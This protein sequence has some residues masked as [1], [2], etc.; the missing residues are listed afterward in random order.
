[1]NIFIKDFFSKC[2]K[3]CNL[4]RI[5]SHLLNKSLMENFICAVIPNQVSQ[6]S[7]ICYKCWYCYWY[8]FTIRYIIHSFTCF[9]YLASEMCTDFFVSLFI[10]KVLATSCIH[11]IQSRWVFNFLLHRD[12]FSS[13]PNICCILGM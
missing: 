3:I 13:V 9:D 6:L 11:F 4:L 8:Y 5:W 12:I 7:F 10:S 2:D 1:M